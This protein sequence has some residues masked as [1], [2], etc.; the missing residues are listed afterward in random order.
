MDFNKQWILFKD[1]LLSIRFGY[2]GFLFYKFNTQWE[3]S[4]NA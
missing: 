4:A 1:K 3:V 2:K